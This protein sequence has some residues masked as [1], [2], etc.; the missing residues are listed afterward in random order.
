MN[1]EAENLRAEQIFLSCLFGSEHGVGTAL[2]AAAFLSCLFG[3]EL[4]FSVFVYAGHFLSCLF[5]SEL[6]FGLVEPGP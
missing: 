1:S 4:F 3:S 5:G 2:L 6:R